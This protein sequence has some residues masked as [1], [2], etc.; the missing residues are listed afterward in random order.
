[1]T[2]CRA[3]DYPELARESALPSASVEQVTLVSAGAAAPKPNQDSDANACSY[4]ETYREAV[5]GGPYVAT[6]AAYPQPSIYVS[7]LVAP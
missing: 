1:M 7:P 6:T 3:I 2:V 5:R 4:G